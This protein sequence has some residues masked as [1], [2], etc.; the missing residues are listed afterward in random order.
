MNRGPRIWYKNDQILWISDE[1]F[2]AVRWI[3]Q[4]TGPDPRGKSLGHAV[5]IRGG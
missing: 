4:L 2:V 5:F 3:R 1:D